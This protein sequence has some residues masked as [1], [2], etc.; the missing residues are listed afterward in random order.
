MP[1]GH[2]AEIMST[3]VTSI[4]CVGPL[5]LLLTAALWVAVVLRSALLLLVP[6]VELAAAL[7]PPLPYVPLPGLPELLA[8]F[9]FP[10]TRTLWPRCWLRSWDE[11]S[12]IACPVSGCR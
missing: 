2:V 6:P 1:A 3:R 11:F 10:S 7:E 5:T 9:M 4:S 8:W 12:L